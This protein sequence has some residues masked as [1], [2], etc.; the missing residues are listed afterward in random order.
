MTQKPYALILDTCVASDILNVDAEIFV[1]AA[2]YLG[3]ICMPAVLIDEL[4]ECFQ[5]VDPSEMGVDEIA[6][7]DEDRIEAV[8][9]RERPGKSALSENDCACAILAA[10]LKCRCVTNDK[11]LQKTCEEL[12]VPVWWGLEMVLELC[13]RGGISFDRAEAFIIGLCR[14]TPYVNEK[15]EERFRARL[16]KIKARK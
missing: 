2:R 5:I 8:D 15:I 1:L 9:L 3:S 11:L 12:G 13:D 16:E 10:R 4:R 14:L 7:T 6:L